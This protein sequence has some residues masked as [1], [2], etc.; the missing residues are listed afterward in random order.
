MVSLRVYASINS[1]SDRFW[2]NIAATIHR[3][4]ITLFKPLKNTEQ[5]LGLGKVCFASVAVIHSIVVDT[6][7]HDETCEQE[8][9]AI[10]FTRESFTIED[11]G[12][13]IT[14]KVPLVHEAKAPGESFV[15][16]QDGMV[17]QRNS[18]KVIG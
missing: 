18:A 17:K 9:C 14:S 16:S 8:T 4:A 13:G 5:L 6:I 7:R 2:A 11:L 1:E 12:V 3:A 15:A 10:Y